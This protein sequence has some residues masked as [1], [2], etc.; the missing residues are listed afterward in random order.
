[1]RPNQ[2]DTE[3]T[4]CSNVVKAAIHR[5]IEHQ[6]ACRGD[7]VAV[8]D[9]GR[10]VTYRELNLRANAIARHLMASG[11][12][13]RGHA[14]VRMPRGADVAAVLLAVLKAGACYT[15]IDPSGPSLAWPRGVSIRVGGDAY[16]NRYLNVDV[17]RF[18]QETVA[19][20]P[21]LPV[22]TRG[23]DLAF[24]LV[25]DNGVP[26]VHVPHETIVALRDEVPPGHR[27][28]RDP[29]LIDL[30]LVLMAGR[31]VTIEPPIRVA[32]A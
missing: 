29:A 3:K 11:L 8:I 22:L 15:W 26:A 2:G 10:S 20:S 17:S 23:S 21:N 13:R 24:V 31:V 4:T 19:P 16:T 27:W 1:M 5:L 12:H 7:A 30:W 14:V 18:L 6:A 9:A 25:G 32:A 28:G